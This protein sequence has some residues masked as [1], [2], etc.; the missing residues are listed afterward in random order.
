MSQCSKIYFL[1]SVNSL[2]SS[3]NMSVIQPLTRMGSESY[4][5]LKS[6]PTKVYSISAAAFSAAGN[7]P[8][9]GVA[10]SFGNRYSSF[11]G[12]LL[13]VCEFGSYF[14][15][16]IRNFQEIREKL[17]SGNRS[18]TP[19]LAVE[20][21]SRVEMREV[22][23]D[24]G[25]KSK[26]TSVSSES[27]AN[28]TVKN[29][30]NWKAIALKTGIAALG[31][32]SQFPL[33]VLVYYGNGGILAYP[34]LSG[35]CDASFTMLSL[36]LSLPKNQKLDEDTI[37]RREAL[38]TQID[39]FLEEL[40]TKYRDPAFS[41]KIDEI[42]SQEKSNEEQGKELLELV[43]EAQ[44]LPELQKGRWDGAMS[45]LAK[46]IGYLISGYLTAVNGAVSYKGILAW[47]KDQAELA[48]I[49][50]ILVSLANIK[51]L[52][53]LCVNS[54][55]NYYEGMRDIFKG[56]YRPPLACSVSPVSWF[57][58]RSISNVV[59][60]F[61]FGTNALG[62]RDYFPKIGNALIWPAP[63]SS[64]LILNDTLAMTSDDIL[65]WMHS[66]SNR[67]V[68]RISHINSGLQKFKE[69]I[70]NADTG[71]L[72]GLLSQFT[73]RIINQPRLADITTP[74]LEG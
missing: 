30:W 16:R 38:V 46:G 11:F 26:L 47:K 74:L 65:L 39:R 44:G 42:F 23:S 13:G 29:S 21:S 48:V 73:G 14:A 57:I 66:K 58:G 7:W 50:T 69:K 17:F 35:V 34:I 33:M 45:N 31:L 36:L 40:P 72:N 4:C 62:A 63:L 56:Q 49:T 53:N 12:N 18:V 19:A 10:A 59:S 32:I 27:T 51:L 67:N 25:E 20:S 9:Y 61:S 55:K 8:Y 54:A 3:F 60:W 70:Q 28:Q 1:M 43:F 52:T 5:S 68:Q 22:I 64:T 37:A 2:F 6:L 71:E 15:F 41:Q 24:D